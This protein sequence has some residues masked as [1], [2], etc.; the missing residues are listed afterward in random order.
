MATLLS[1]A[2]RR[3]D[4][5]DLSLTEAELDEVTPLLYG[6]GG[7]ALAWKRVAKT[8]LRNTAS[9]ELL[10]Q[11]YRLHSLQAAMHEQRIAKVFRLFREARVDAILAKGWVAAG[12]YVE[13]ALRP[14]GDIDLCVRP[15]HRKA[16]REV[17]STPEANDCWVDLHNHFLEL[18][19][20]A[21]DEIFGRARLA[22]LGG[23]PIRTLGP[24]DHLALL[25]IH[26]LKHGAWRPI[27][28]CDIGAAVET[29]AEGFNW[30]ICLGR[31]RTRASWIASAV[32]LA[33]RL[34]HADTVK[35]PIQAEV[36]LPAWL[37]ENVLNQWA[38]PFAIDQ[39]PNTHPVPM[40]QLL[41]HP[42]GLPEGL[43][44]RWPNAIIATISVH[45]RLNSLPRL[46]YQVANCVARMGHLLVHQSA[47][48]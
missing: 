41:R 20:R 19:E 22:H 25:C 23:E 10:H 12:M 8:H 5:P 21:V 17:L 45:G 31:D 32:G 35:L 15:E 30:K 4:L 27:W 39:P 1:R 36:R 42:A 26:L 3:E 29:L 40:A 48:D 38:H 44:K 28:L 24:E 37:I 16:A 14:Y 34:L 9:A 18:D 47:D 7:A 6:S 46:P 13:T 2:W 33:G 43:R 11:A